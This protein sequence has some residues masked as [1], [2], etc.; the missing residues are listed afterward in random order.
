M[1]KLPFVAGVALLLLTQAALA[2]NPVTITHTSQADFAAAEVKNVMVWS[3]GELTLAPAT[4]AILKSHENV[5]AVSALA[6]TEA[7]E[8]I[9]GTATQGLVLRI[10]RDGAVSELANLDSVIVTGLV[11]DGSSVYA[12]TSGR[13]AGVYRIDMKGSKPKVK[14]LWSDEQAASVWS[15]A[16]MGGT[17]FAATAPHGKVFAIEPDGSAQVIFTAKQAVL[18]SIVVA[19][20]AVLVGTGED[21]LVYRLEKSGAKWTSRV[22]L[23]GEENEI[24]ALAVDADGAV[25]AAAASPGSPTPTSPAESDMGR[26]AAK[27]SASPDSGP[28]SQPASSPVGRAAPRRSGQAAAPNKEAANSHGGEKSPAVPAPAAVQKEEEEASDVASAPAP[29]DAAARGGENHEVD[30]SSENAA[31][32]GAAPETRPAEPSGRRGGRARGPAGATKGNTVYRIGPDGFVKVV[33]RQAQTIGG[34]VLSQ[35]RLYVATSGEQAAVQEVNLDSGAWG[36]LGKF[37]PHQM[38]VLAAGRDGTLLAG[39][40]DAASVI[41]I[42]K[43]LASKGTLIGTVMD[44]EQIARWSSIDIQSDLPEG[45]S[46]TVATRTGNVSEVAE[47]TWSDWSAEVP[48]GKGWMPLASPVGRFCQYRLTLTRAGRG[49][50]ELSPV[51]DAVQVVHQVGNLPPDIESVTS[52]AVDQTK[53]PQAAKEPGPLRYRQIKIKATDGNKDELRYTLYYRQRGSAVWVKV[54]NDLDKPGY[55]WDTL[56]VPDGQYEVKVEASDAAA[57]SPERALKHSW[58]SRTIVVD[59]TPPVI[60]ELSARPEG[61]TIHLNVTATDASRIAGMEY[62]LDSAEKPVIMD[63]ADGIYDSPVEKAAV[64]IKD[65]SPGAH[66][67]TVKVRDEFGN[68]SYQAVFVHVPEKG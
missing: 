58:I 12:S 62:V 47:G 1:P 52:E 7:G 35:G 10:G 17:L 48:A 61:K 6:M 45:T 25:Y 29:H 23:D 37:E 38:T 36:I 46:V 4:E 57:N 20:K 8:T 50:Q 2:V 26:P 41:R 19:G 33:V 64:T 5:E 60:A 21:G 65:V 49:G 34:M 15:I 67:I 13:A 39:T 68:A 18:R 24:V 27:P 14:K 3:L 42:D 66:V 28:S 31:A 55:A 44:A 63:A 32:S 53:V 30:K 43:G 9:V 54:E 59:N 22:L 11:V 40:A 16:R 56:T 51:V